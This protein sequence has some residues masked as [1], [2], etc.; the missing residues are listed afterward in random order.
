[1]T[2]RFAPQ[3]S[4][5]AAPSGDSLQINPRWRYFTANPT[6][7]IDSIVAQVNIDMIGRGRGDDLPGGGPDY[8]GVVGSSFDSRDLGELVREVNRRQPAPLSL[9]NKYDT[10]LTWSGYNNIYGRSDHYMYAQKGIPIAFFFTGLHGDYHQR[11]DE[12]QYIDFPHYTRITRYIGDLVVAVGNAPRP[13]TRG[14]AAG[15]RPRGSRRRSSR[16]GEAS[17]RPD[18]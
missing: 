3:A 9:D 18:R 12:A 11:S 7:P 1:M 14:R 17:S 5:Q 6:V 2:R 13:R 10:T 8:L 16:P 15:H 4:D